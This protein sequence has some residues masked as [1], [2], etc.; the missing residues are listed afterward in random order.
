[1]NLELIASLPK[2]I[3]YN[4][5]IFGFRKGLRIKV[6]F[7]YKT[8]VNVHRGGIEVFDSAGSGAV[9][10]GF[11]GTDGIVG[12]S[13]SIIIRNGKVKFLGKANLASGVS[14]RAD[15]GCI[16]FGD[17]F[18][19][20]KNCFFSSNSLV[21]FGNDVLLG[22]NIS[23]RDG[24]GHPIWTSNVKNDDCSPIMIGNHV[25]IAADVDIL[26]GAMVP[27]GCIVAC[28]SLVTKKFDDKFKDSVIG[29]IPAKCI[30]TNIKWERE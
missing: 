17:N 19:C 27:D 21:K 30:K 7:H 22:W 29:G 23:I 8:N 1:M 3:Y 25:W 13:S 10:I 26:K 15:K 28:R 11:G 20:N 24:D 6:L 4:I 12:Q 16:T 18:S 2:T 5:K 14:I 9:K